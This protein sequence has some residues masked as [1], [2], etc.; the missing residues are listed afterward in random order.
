MSF[1]YVSERRCSIG[2]ASGTQFVV[3]VSFFCVIQM[4]F[5]SKAT[6]SA[7]VNLYK[8]SS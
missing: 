5:Y 8:E 6:T 7:E 4:G 2:A 3:P 1:F